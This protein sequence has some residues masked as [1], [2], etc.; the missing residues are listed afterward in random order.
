MPGKNKSKLF[1]YYIHALNTLD[2][3]LIKVL[4]KYNACKLLI[5]HFTTTVIGQKPH[6][7]EMLV[8]TVYMYNL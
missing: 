2:N 3:N 4:I 7:I 1:I 6:E 8:N 5:L